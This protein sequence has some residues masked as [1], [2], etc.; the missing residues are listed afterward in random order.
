MA[1][2]TD[3]VILRCDL[4]QE[5]VREVMATSRILVLMRRSWAVAGFMFAALL[6]EAMALLRETGRLFLLLDQENRHV[7]GFIPKQSTG[8]LPP[9]PGPGDLIRERISAGAP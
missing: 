4:G 2:T 3:S 9:E 5:D 7:R 8:G 1:G 6:G